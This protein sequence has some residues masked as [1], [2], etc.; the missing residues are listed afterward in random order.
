MLLRF[1]F[2]KK[3]VT[4]LI[5]SVHLFKLATRCWLKYDLKRKATIIKQKH[6]S[7]GHAYDILSNKY[8]IVYISIHNILLKLNLMSAETHVINIDN[9]QKNDT[10]IYSQ[11]YFSVAFRH[12]VSLLGNACLVGV[13]TVLLHHGTRWMSLTSG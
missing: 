7:T 4:D 9:R 2:L 5:N 1:S 13:Y 6:N 8:T 12:H 11:N 3:K 10:Q